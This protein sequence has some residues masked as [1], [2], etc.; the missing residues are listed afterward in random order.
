MIS[1]RSAR[2]GGDG[3]IMDEAVEAGY[4]N[5]LRPCG[6]RPSKAPAPKNVSIFQPAPPV[7]AETSGFIASMSLRVF[8]PAPPV[9]AET[10]YVEPYGKAQR[11]STRSARVGGDNG[12]CLRQ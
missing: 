4:F 9:W 11:I 2:V 8:Q 3:R 6:R 7:W 12:R 5:P 10:P 1:T